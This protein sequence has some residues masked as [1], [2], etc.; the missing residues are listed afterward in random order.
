LHGLG[1]PIEVENSKSP[2]HENAMTFSVE[3]RARSDRLCRTIAI[4][5]KSK[6][7]LSVWSAMAQT[8]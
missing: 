6:K 7:A 8:A 4:P 1:A 3:T 2:V 5:V